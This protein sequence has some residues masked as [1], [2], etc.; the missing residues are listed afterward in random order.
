[1]IVALFVIVTAFLWLLHETDYLRIRLPVGGKVYKVFHSVT[2][3]A[4]TVTA[5]PFI[6]LPDNTTV[7]PEHPAA[8]CRLV[9]A[10]IVGLPKPEI[11]YLLPQVCEL[12]KLQAKFKDTHYSW[13]YGTS[14]ND[15]RRESYQSMT[16]SGY[17]ITV[18]ATSAKLHDVIA[19]AQKIAN[20]KARKVSFKPYPLSSFIETVMIGSH[21]EPDSWIANDGKE[22][23]STRTIT[24]Y[25][26]NFRDCLC[27]KEWLEAHYKD[28][29]PEPTIELSVDGKILS[30]NGNYK[31]GKIKEFI[32][33]NREG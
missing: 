17:N 12:T 5:I 23:H 22:Y 25:T 8:V 10:I 30:L 29:Y 11:V 28:E 13:R 1:M 6:V 20:G 14:Y 9:N 4:S 7:N 27:G 32:K 21:Q 31:A 26:T 15:K 3:L 18:N 33:A 16:V 24:D 19:E 2:V